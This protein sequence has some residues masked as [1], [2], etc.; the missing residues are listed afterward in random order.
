MK[1]TTWLKFVAPMAPYV[2]VLVGLY[3]FNSAWTAILLYHFGIVLL[4]IGD[5][6][7][8]LLK[9]IRSGRN[10][11]A[12]GVSVAVCALSGPAIFFLWQYMRLGRVSLKMTLMNFGLYGTSWYIFIVYFATVH[13]FLEELYWRGYLESSHK[14][15]SWVDLAFAGYHVFVLAL[16]IKL[17]WVVVSFIVFSVA[18]W[19]WRCI[20]HRFEGLA[21]PLLS[22]LV[23]D[24]SIIAVINVLAR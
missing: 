14:Y 11:I 16:F 21:V 7:D 13:P 4:L 3:V 2:S 8:K 15:A 20:A 24:V 12:A 10:S 1:K 22:H 9:N 17:P 5:S 19:S 23:A 6:R 18:A